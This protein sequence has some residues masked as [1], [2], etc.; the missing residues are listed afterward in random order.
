LK[1][2]EL[3]G[4]DNP[5]EARFCM[6]CGSDLDAVSAP[7]VP[8]DVFEASTFTPAGEVDRHGGGRSKSAP[9]QPTEDKETYKEAA[10]SESPGI[11]VG[12]GDEGEPPEIQQTGVTADFAGKKSYCERCREIRNIVW[13][14]VSR[15]V[16][17]RLRPTNRPNPLRWTM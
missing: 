17:S 10:A 2:C 7:D 8:V 5:E 9:P 6:K 16:M 11:F 4:L 14:A 3:C 1:H 12:A 15:L 13:A